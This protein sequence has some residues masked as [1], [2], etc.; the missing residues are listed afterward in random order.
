MKMKL[1]N[2]VKNALAKFIEGEV[3]E[4]NKDDGYHKINITEPEFGHIVIDIEEHR[5]EVTAQ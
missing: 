3:N 1:G 2:K 5:T 4:Y